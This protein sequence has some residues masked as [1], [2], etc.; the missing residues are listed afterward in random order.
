MFLWRPRSALKF[1]YGEI[2]SFCEFNDDKLILSH[3]EDFYIGSWEFLM[4]KANLIVEDE[5]LD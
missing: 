4:V 5:G 2:F 1:V 3:V